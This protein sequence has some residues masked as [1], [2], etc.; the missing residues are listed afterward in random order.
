MALRDT[1]GFCLNYLVHE[2]AHK[3]LVSAPVPLEFGIGMKWVGDGP[4]GFGDLIN[5]NLMQ[6]YILN[7]MMMIS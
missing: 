1:W 2:V 6:G 3:I 7:P 5:K 4:W